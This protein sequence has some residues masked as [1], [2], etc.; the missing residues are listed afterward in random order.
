MQFLNPTD[1]EN[2]SA[3]GLIAFIHERADRGKVYVADVQ[4]SGSWGAFNQLKHINAPDDAVLIP[5]SAAPTLTRF[6][7][8]VEWSRATDNPVTGARSC[9]YWSYHLQPG[10]LGV[11][12]DVGIR[13]AIDL[14]QPTWTTRELRFAPTRGGRNHLSLRRYVVSASYGDELTDRVLLYYRQLID[15]S[16]VIPVLTNAYAIPTHWCVDPGPLGE[17]DDNDPETEI[18][19]RLVSANNRSFTIRMIPGT[20]AAIMARELSTGGIEIVWYDV[21]RRSAGATEQQIAAFA[22]ALPENLRGLGARR[23]PA[24]DT[25]NYPATGTA[26]VIYAIFHSALGGSRIETWL[27]YYDNALPRPYSMADRDTSGLGFATAVQV[28]EHE[29]HP[30]PT[31]LG[32][33]GAEIEDDES[34]V[35]VDQR[36]YL[37]LALR[38]TDIAD[39]RLQFWVVSAFSPS[40]DPQQLPRVE[41]PTSIEHSPN[42]DARD[43]EPMP[44]SSGVFQYYRVKEP[45]PF[46]QM[47]PMFRFRRGGT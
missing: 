31:V 35:G 5:P 15:S 7:N 2:D 4:G 13:Q 42:A 37:T 36:P 20:Y 23:A 22:T 41:L 14:G 3:T 45:N 21:G 18:P 30:A 32:W 9:L 46:A 28:V 19:D 6:P 8:G 26:Y 25:Y 43:A 29:A 1:H 24:F 11:N 33:T 34:Y 40:Q 16:M 47:V 17:V 10:A 27:A 12:D 38:N 44:L 39:R